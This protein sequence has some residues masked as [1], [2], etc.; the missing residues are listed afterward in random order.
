[1]KIYISTPINARTE[2]T[3]FDKWRAAKHR[4]ALLSEVIEDDERFFRNGALV[5]TSTFSE[6]SD[7]QIADGSLSEAQAMGD[8]VRLVMEADAIYLDHGWGGSKGCN[9]EYRT[10][11]IYG[12]AIYEHDKM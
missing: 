2:R 8:C 1:M 10:A 4:C 6:H 11:K 12:K 9:L 3:F 7:W 5:I